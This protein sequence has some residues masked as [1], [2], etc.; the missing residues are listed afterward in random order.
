MAKKFGWWCPWCSTWV[1]VKDTYVQD[2]Q[3]WHTYCDNVVDKRQQLVPMKPSPPTPEVQA[4]HARH[5][6][7][8]RDFMRVAGRYNN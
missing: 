4:D 7:M 8:L 1:D 2:G 5:A 6:K 3:R